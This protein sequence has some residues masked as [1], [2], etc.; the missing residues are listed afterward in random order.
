MK[1]HS[2]NRVALVT[3]AARG[4]GQVFA[5]RLAQDGCKLVLVDLGPCEQTRGLVERAGSSAWDIPC[6][7][8]DGDAVERLIGQATA[9]TGG[10]DILVNNAAF[11][12]MMAWHELKAATL[13]RIL[14][15][16]TE[17]SFLLAQGFAPKMI[18]RG[19]GRIVNLASSSAWAPPP[20]FTGYIASKMANIGL[21]RSLALELGDQGITVNA[22]APGLTRT[23]AAARD[24]PD[25]I[26]E[27]VKGQQ[28]IHR[29]G[30]P[31]DLVGAMSFLCS[32]DAAF[33]TG[34]TLHVD[35]GA[36]LG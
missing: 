30:E 15:V 17:A 7:L 27:R 33:I 14:A 3:G 8:A 18:E 20:G 36:V 16:N 29:V 2:T 28:L 4:L 24:V 6:D 22:I 11:Q 35:G 5:E 31:R 13:R 19:W 32:D 23:E 34:Q 26:W 21:M 10:I 12:P 1:R 9:A 25:F